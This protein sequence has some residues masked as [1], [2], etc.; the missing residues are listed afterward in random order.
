[1]PQVSPQAFDFFVPWEVVWGWE[2]CTTLCLVGMKLL[3]AVGVWMPLNSPVRLSWS[4]ANNER[5]NPPQ[6]VKN[7]RVLR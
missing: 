6:N 1:M 3:L 4:S 7:V 5:H 2:L